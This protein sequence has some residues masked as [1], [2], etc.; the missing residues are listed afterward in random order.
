MNYTDVAIGIAVGYFFRKQIAGLLGGMKK[1]EQKLKEDLGAL[2]YG[3]GAVGLHGH[4]GPSGWSGQ[5]GLSPLPGY[6]AVHLN[7]GTHQMGAIHMNPAYGAVHLNP[8]H[9]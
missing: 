5:K 7:R 1:D 6:G 4:Q 9:L 2:A 8:R 3:Y